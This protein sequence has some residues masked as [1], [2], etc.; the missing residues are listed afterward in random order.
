MYN[1]DNFKIFGH[2]MWRWGSWSLNLYG[3][4]SACRTVSYAQLASIAVFGLRCCSEV[5]ERR[6]VSG[7]VCIYRED[8]ILRSTLGTIQVELSA[9]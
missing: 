2:G 1:F 6:R 5:L 9:F 8:G 4:R 3:V 7:V